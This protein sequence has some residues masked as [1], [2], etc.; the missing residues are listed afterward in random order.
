MPQQQRYCPQQYM[1]PQCQNQYYLRPVVQYRTQQPNFANPMAGQM[2]V[3][4]L[5]NQRVAPP[6]ASNNSTAAVPEIEPVIDGSVQ[7]A[8]AEMEDLPMIEELIVDPEVLPAGDIPIDPII[9][10]NSS[11][12][13][14]SVLE[15]G[16]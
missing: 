15:K 6:T 10:G 3:P 16:K 11:T 4:S 5:A 7:P 2:S 13:E 8:A 14:N 12:L 1:R 9:N